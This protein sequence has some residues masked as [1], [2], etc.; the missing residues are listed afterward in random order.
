M[1]KDFKTIG[2]LVRYL[3]DEMVRTHK[4]PFDTVSDNYYLIP[5]C[6]HLFR[7][8]N[9]DTEKLMDGIYSGCTDAKQVKE[10]LLFDYCVLKLQEFQKSRSINSYKHYLMQD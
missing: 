6:T 3:T 4:D 2:Q 9:L 1:V 7:L 5:K 8:S 10:E